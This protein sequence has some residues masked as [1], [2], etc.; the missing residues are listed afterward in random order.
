MWEREAP[1]QSLRGALKVL[2]LFRCGAACAAVGLSVC[3]QDTHPGV[4]GAR[5]LGLID[6]NLQ[7]FSKLF[8]TKG[9]V[10]SLADVFTELQSRRLNLPRSSNGRARAKAV[11]NKNRVL[12]RAIDG[13]R[14]GVLNPPSCFRD[15][16]Q[17]ANGAGRISLR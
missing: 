11:I 12:L 8:G 16:G 6:S 10:V 4:N 5:N 9:I 14:E 3:S 17:Q 13:D 2:G 1:L 15:Y 7:L